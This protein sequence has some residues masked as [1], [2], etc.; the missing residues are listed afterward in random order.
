MYNF[1]TVIF[2]NISNIGDFPNI[3]IELGYNI[4]QFT[5]NAIYFKYFLIRDIFN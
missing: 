1:Q 3:V 2:N 4:L 5:N